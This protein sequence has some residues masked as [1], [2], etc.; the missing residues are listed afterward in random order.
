MG[1]GYEAGGTAQSQPLDRLRRILPLP[2]GGVSRTIGFA[3]GLA[4]AITL[5]MQVSHLPSGVRLALRCL[6]YYWPGSRHERTAAFIRWLCTGRA[7]LPP[8]QCGRL[9]GT[10]AAMS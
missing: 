7:V 4:A 9:R 2:P 8:F 6:G 10:Q 3:S 5:H 1:H